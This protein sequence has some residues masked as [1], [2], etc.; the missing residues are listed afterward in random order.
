MLDRADVAN[1]IGAPTRAMAGRRSYA[2]VAAAI[3]QVTPGA[4][5]FAVETSEMNGHTF[6]L[7]AAARGAFGWV[8]RRGRAPG[9]DFG[10]D[11]FEVESPLASLR[12]V[13]AVWRA[14]F[15]L[16]VVVVAGSVG[17]TTTKE[18][19]AAMLRGRY[20]HVLATPGN[21][22][23]FY[24]IA[25]TLADLDAGHDAA[26]VEVGIDEP[27]AM[28]DHMRIVAA[29]HAVVTAVAAEHL[30]KLHDVETVAKE[31][32]RALA[33][34]A[35]RGGTTAVNMDD[36]YIRAWADA[37]HGGRRIGFSMGEA[38][39]ASDTV[40][41]GRRLPD[42]RTL[43]LDGLGLRREPLPVPLPGRHNAQN[44]LAAA[45]VAR[46]L[47]LSAGEMAS[48]LATFRPVPGRCSI[49][50]I[51]GLTVIGDYYNASPASML[52]AFEFLSET[53]KPRWACLGDMLEL[54]DSEQRLH[55]DLASPIVEAA[56]EHVL[57]IGRRMAWLADELRERGYPGD[58]A[59]HKSHDALA[60]DVR[61]R[62]VPG[63]IVLIKGSR[64]AGMEKI[65]AILK[66][67]E[68]NPGPRV[69]RGT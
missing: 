67:C 52:A 1:L 31:E 9:L 34:T 56:I 40:L 41:V 6:L 5:Y 16:P 28:D 63:D 61:A 8:C 45:A 50:R 18:L 35:T 23:G 32:T 48:G 20:Q 39:P 46:T 22:N 30:E 66:H 65:L 27:G 13:A 55:R 43:E 51:G 62:A 11:V 15:D 7:D 53:G 69:P 29:T 26:V 44:V 33:A 12:E 24:G 25:A 36:P 10:I 68:R 3:D 47:G 21:L 64:G 58:L 42:A 14:R 38:T 59:V 54:G 19:L 37:S 60:N 49:E 2:R 17:K 4:L 57:L